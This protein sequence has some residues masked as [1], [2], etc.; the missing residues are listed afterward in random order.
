VDSYK[1][2]FSS[3]ETIDTSGRGY[4]LGDRSDKGVYVYQEDIELAVNVALATGR[5]LL[6]SGEPGTGKSSLAADVADRMKWRFYT[7]TISSSTRARDLLWTF[8]TIKRLSDAQAG[9][10]G[11]G[12]KHDAAYI[13][14]GVLWWAFDRESAVLRGISETECN[15]HKVNKAVDR[16][17]SVSSSRSVV[18]LDEMDKADPDVP[19]NLLGPLGSFEFVLDGIQ[20]EES[21][22]R[23]IKAMEAPLIIITTNNERD[24]PRAFIRRCI[25]LTLQLPDDTRLL[26][27]ARKHFPDNDVLLHEKVLEMF[28]VIRNEPGSDRRQK[29]STAEFL[30]AIGACSGLSIDPNADDWLIRFEQVANITLRKEQEIEA[31]QSGS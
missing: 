25:C 29:P 8:D 18:L 30:D 28:K 7:K 9:T 17:S 23:V 1:P 5:P 20:E 6:I 16:Q 14:P 26:E 11:E 2:L 31:G 27:I 24:L 3:K 10:K 22:P 12:V 13:N 15:T 21:E 4:G 19:N